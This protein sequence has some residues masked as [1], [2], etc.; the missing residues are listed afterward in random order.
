MLQ[1]NEQTFVCTITKGPTALLTAVVV[2]NAIGHM[3]E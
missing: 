2:D 1:K 3:M